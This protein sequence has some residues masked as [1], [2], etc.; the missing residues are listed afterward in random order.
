MKTLPTTS[1]VELIDKKKFA[2]VALDTNL[3]TFVLY[4]S[5]LK[6]IKRPTIYLFQAAQI[7]IL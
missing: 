7:A 6:A 1:Q 4:I 2:K 3:E 5:A